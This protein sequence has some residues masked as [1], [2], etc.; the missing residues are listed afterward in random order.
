MI[1]FFLLLISLTNVGI[2]KRSKATLPEQW[3][4]FYRDGEANPIIVTSCSVEFTPSAMPQYHL[5]LPITKSCYR[6]GTYSRC[7]SKWENPMRHMFGFFHEVKIIH[8]RGK[9][10]HIIISFHIWCDGQSW[11][12]HGSM[13]MG[14]RL[15]LPQLN[16]QV[17]Q[18]GNYY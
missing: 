13:A 18:D 3:V 1:G 8:T 2:G 10:K 12:G 15:L 17:C 16:H 7:F 4:G 9:E 14:G 6:V 11:S 5:S